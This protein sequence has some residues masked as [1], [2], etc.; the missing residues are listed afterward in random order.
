M[1]QRERDMVELEALLVEV[2]QVDYYHNQLIARL[3][4]LILK[5]DGR[6]VN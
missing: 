6:K 4:R 3:Q 2:T 1:D 5:M